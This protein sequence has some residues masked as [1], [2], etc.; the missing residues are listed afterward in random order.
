MTAR[1]RRGAGDGGIVTLI[2]GLAGG[3][4]AGK[5]SIVRGLVERIGGC[6]IDLE[7]YTLDR[8]AGPLEERS[9]IGDDEPAA[10][11]TSL[12]VTHLEDLR[13][14]EAIR[15]PVYSLEKHART[16]TAI[17][18]PARLVL[19]EGLFTLW[20]ESI[21]ALL[22]LK[23][24]V[25]AP[26]DLRLMR[27]IRRD[28]A[29]R[30]RTVEQVL[31]QYSSSV[32]SAHE[33]YVEP[34]R[35]HADDV[36]TNDGPLED[37]VDQVLALVRRHRADGLAP[38]GQRQAMSVQ[39]GRSMI[40]PARCDYRAKWMEF[41]RRLGSCVTLDELAPKLVDAAAETLGAAGAVLYLAKAGAGGLR[42][43]AAVGAGC[44]AP[45]V[46]DDDHAPFAPLL[47]GREPVVLENG[48][49]AAWCWLTDA[50]MFTE[51]SAIVPLR[52]H[53]EPIGALVVGEPVG[54]PYTRDDQGLMEAIGEHAAGLI[55]TV[56]MSE[57]RTRA[58]EFEAFH[59]L[60]SSVVHD[61]KSS[62]AALSTLSESAFKKI[63]DRELQRDELSTVAQTVTRMQ[64]LLGRLREVPH[65]G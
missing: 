13:R 22:D 57:R 9:A 40:P 35:V 47:A 3:T 55:V 44:P 8:S 2:I 46:A 32:R 14:G 25:H 29:D 11:D 28:L 65:R 54:T 31:Y 21:R 60:A 38:A 37:A 17:V 5:S 59:R 53:D 58:R 36:V 45:A 7:S 39:N 12:L 43:I 61:L 15:R 64:S 19:V 56:Q 16:G 33:R 49:A 26:A 4:G 1:P 62:I 34:T 51:G 6:V 41:T 30:G 42:A 18:A 23:V 10:I 20:W 63:D 27:R 52:W 50:R 48:S 24:F